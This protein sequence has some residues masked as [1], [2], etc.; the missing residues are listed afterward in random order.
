MVSPKM[1]VI[2]EETVHWMFSDAEE[3]GTSDISCCVNS[4]LDNYYGKNA[5]VSSETRFK[6]RSAVMT[7][8]RT[9]DYD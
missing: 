2:I 8:I 9:I 5:E 6:V 3:I 4:C 7:A 1:L